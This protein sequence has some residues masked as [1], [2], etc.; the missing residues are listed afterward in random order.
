MSLLL[1]T[2]SC[3]LNPQAFKS[4]SVYKADYFITPLRAKEKAELVIA[5][6]MDRH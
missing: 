6:F 1:G 5:V 3:K 2:D 4:E